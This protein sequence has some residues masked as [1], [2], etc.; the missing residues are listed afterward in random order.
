M[1]QQT[2]VARTREAG[3]VAHLSKPAAASDIERLAASDEG[4]VLPMKRERGS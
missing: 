4:I 3:F 2:D 1:G